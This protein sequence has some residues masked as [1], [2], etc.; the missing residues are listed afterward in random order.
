[1]N[2]KY[3]VFIWSSYALTLAVLV[4][5]ALAPWLRRNEWR[6]RRSEAANEEADV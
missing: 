5:N 2:P 6:R 4:W 1:M 3:A